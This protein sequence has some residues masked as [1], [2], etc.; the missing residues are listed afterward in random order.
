MFELQ[1]ILSLDVALKA[2]PDRWW[3]T[4]K[5]TIHGRGHCQR[6]MMVRFSYLEVY[7]ARR[8]D[9]WNDPTNHLMEFQALWASRPNDEWVHAFVH[10]LDELLRSWYVAAKM[11]RTITTLEE[12]SIFF[13]QTFSFQ[14]EN[15]EVHNVLHIICYIVL[16]ERNSM[17]WGTT[18]DSL[19][20]EINPFQYAIEIKYLTLKDQ[21]SYLILAGVPQQTA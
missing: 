6:L 4:H 16:M 15:P 21:T 1:R 20:P 10:T 2:T 12:L 19:N 9:G 8:Y 11:R 17:D 18:T 3:A 14:D 13:A 7:H 5:Q